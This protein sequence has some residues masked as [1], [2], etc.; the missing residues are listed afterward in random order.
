M[1]IRTNSGD[2][3]GTEFTVRAPAGS[4]TENRE[5]PMSI[6]NGIVSRN[7]AATISL[8]GA[9]VA[10]CRLAAEQSAAASRACTAAR[11]GPKLT[12]SGGYPDQGAGPRCQGH[13]QGTPESHPRRGDNDRRTAGA[14]GH[15]AQQRQEQE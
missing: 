15:C 4:Y 3:K 1:T 9:A 10:V 13:G 2:G 7:R 8:P 14:R 11:K 5:F 12:V 6:D